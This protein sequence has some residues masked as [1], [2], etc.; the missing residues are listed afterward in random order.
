M[1]VQGD[2]QSLVNGGTCVDLFRVRVNNLIV[3][4]SAFSKLST[5]KERERERGRKSSW[6]REGRDRGEWLYLSQVVHT[7][8][9]L[10]S[11]KLCAFVPM[12]VQWCSMYMIL[13]CEIIQW[14]DTVPMYSFTYHLFCCTSSCSAVYKHVTV[15]MFV[16]SRTVI[17]CNMYVEW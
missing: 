1:V 13:Y 15:I 16:A 11:W 5:S 3:V 14:S 8:I 6:V 10:A 4:Q 2:V 12:T 9:C 17:A 7:L